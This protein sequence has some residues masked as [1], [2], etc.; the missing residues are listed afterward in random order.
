VSLHDWLG[1]HAADLQN[2]RWD[3][4]HFVSSCTLCGREMIKPPGLPWQLRPVS[5]H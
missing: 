4:G 2:S 3:Q 5:R 1:R